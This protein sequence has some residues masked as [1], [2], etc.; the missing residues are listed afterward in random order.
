MRTEGDR[1]CESTLQTVP[2][3]VKEGASSRGPR[4]TAGALVLAESQLSAGSRAEGSVLHS[5]PTRSGSVT[6]APAG[7][8]RQ[9][10]TSWQRSTTFCQ[11]A[12]LPPAC[13]RC[14]PTS[15]RTPPTPPP[16]FP[17]VSA[18]A[19]PGIVAEPFCPVTLGP[20]SPPF[21]SKEGM[22]RVSCL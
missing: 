16:P 4:V 1:A 15:C 21:L 12:S 20:P 19:H 17:K 11:G 8:S 18:R 7:V 22:R 13:P 5:Q 9:E 10:P 14:P 6:A 2:S 3:S